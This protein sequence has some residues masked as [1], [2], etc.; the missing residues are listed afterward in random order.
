MSSAGGKTGGT[1]SDSTSADLPDPSTLA[2]AEA[3][4]AALVAADRS[5]ATA[6]SLTGGLVS[7][8]LTAVPG[9]SA[10]VRGGVV[11][12]ATEVKESVLRVPAGVLD[13]RGAVSAEAALAMADGVRRLLGADWGVATTGVAGPDP[14]EG[15]PVGTVHVAVT[16]SDGAGAGEEVRVSRALT[17]HGSRSQIR[18]QSVRHVLDLLLVTLDGG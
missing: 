12:Y 13:A 8:A 16:G 15:K 4:V 11:S 5:V 14:A 7:A 17:L 18:D 2:L 9:A 6:E 3:A 1:G 10:V